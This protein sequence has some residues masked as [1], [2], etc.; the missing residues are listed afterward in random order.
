MLGSHQDGQMDHQVNPESKSF[1]RRGQT[2][3]GLREEDAVPM[4]LKPGEMSMHHGFTL[5]ASSPNLSAEHRV[6]VALTYVR[7]S[8]VPH[9]KRGSATLVSGRCDADHWKLFDHRPAGGLPDQ[10]SIEA[11]REA[12]ATHRGD[13]IAKVHTE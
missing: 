11:H 8:T 12:L 9:N 7:P 3:D 10:A 2:V 13:L 5:H 6:G 1:L 4:E